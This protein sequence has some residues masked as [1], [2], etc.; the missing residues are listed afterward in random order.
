PE[1]VAAKV[2][3]AVNTTKTKPASTK[4][5]RQQEEVQPSPTNVPENNNSE[6]A[7]STYTVEVGDSVSL[8]A[9]NH[10]LTIEQLQTLNPEIIEVPIYPGQVLKLKEVTE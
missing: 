3:N 1:K 6:Q 5:S 10:G 2:T 9:E 4:E 8:I 7:V